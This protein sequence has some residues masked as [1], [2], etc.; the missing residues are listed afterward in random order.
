MDVIYDHIDDIITE[1]K[2]IEGEENF[3]WCDSGR[4]YEDC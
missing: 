2:R 4:R 1:A 3:C